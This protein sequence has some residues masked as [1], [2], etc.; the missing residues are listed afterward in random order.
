MRASEACGSLELE[1]AGAT[2]R[3]LFRDVE[4]AI[5]VASA[6]QLL[7]LPGQTMD[8]SMLA[9]GAAQKAATASLTQLTTAASMGDKDC[10]GGAVQDF[11]Q[12]LVALVA[13]ARGLCATSGD[14]TLT[15]KALAATR[16][17]VGESAKVIDEVRTT[18][19]QP[20]PPNQACGSKEY[21]GSAGT[22]VRA[23][24]SSYPR[25]YKYI[26]VFGGIFFYLVVSSCY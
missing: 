5:N 14:K 8:S 7:P 9:L 22:V 18:V 15:A 20:T 24:G 12:A 23:L 16:A 6:G 11:A 26:W 4:E 25:I 1:S 3:G 17:I 21:G 10:T 19:I 2:V 13:H